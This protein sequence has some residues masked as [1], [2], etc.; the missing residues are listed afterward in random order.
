RNLCRSTTPTGIISLSSKEIRMPDLISVGQPA[1]F[2][3]SPSATPVTRQPDA[4]E[5][6]VIAKVTRRLL[7]LLVVCY[8]A[9]F[10]DRVNVSFA[11]LTMNKDIGL[12]ASAYAFG[13]GV[14]F[15]TYFV[16]EIP[17]NLLLERVGARVWI[18]RIMLTWGVLSAANAFIRGPVSF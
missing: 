4:L 8:F 17:S 14:F 13:A 15:L 12:S 7:P 1:P 5:S 18:T 3:G 16:F 10:L 6:T 11:A 2:S 9:A